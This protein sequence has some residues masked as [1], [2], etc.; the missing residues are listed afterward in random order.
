[1]HTHDAPEE[2]LILVVSPDEGR[3]DALRAGLE[4]RG[5]TVVESV[6]DDH[7]F[8]CF[9]LARIDLGDELLAICAL[10]VDLT[11]LVI[12]LRIIQIGHERFEESGQ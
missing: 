6:D 12:Q 7:A 4:A 1:M 10:G 3:R 5:F 11:G 9:E 2:A 8:S